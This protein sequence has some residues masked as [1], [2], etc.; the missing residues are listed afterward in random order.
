MPS[1]VEIVNLALDELGKVALRD[2]STTPTDPVSG[3]LAK[4]R[5]EASRD[6]LIS[7]HDWTFARCTV[8][9]NLVSGVSH[10]DGVVY[11]LPADCFVPR[12]LGP[13]A[14]APSQWSIE[15]RYIIIPT[16]Y[17][18]SWGAQPRLRYTKI[19]TQTTIFPPYFIDALALL[20]ASKLAMPLSADQKVA[21]TLTTM[22]ERS[23]REAALID[24]NIGEGD[25]YMSQDLQYDS[26][27]KTDIP[28]VV[29]SDGN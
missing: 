4:R 27:V 21:S 28:V 1:A 29:F 7:K 17:T 19:V 18:C 12:R 25:D 5:Y 6:L 8:V 10:P 3:R 22:Y 13:R 14:G 9:L 20:I 23:W 16:N 11:G 2:F 26:F 15:G 24:S